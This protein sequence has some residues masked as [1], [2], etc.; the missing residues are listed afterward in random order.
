MLPV[1]PIITAVAPPVLVGLFAALITMWWGAGVALIALAATA[2]A[3]FGGPAFQSIVLVLTAMELLGALRCFRAQALLGNALVV[4]PLNA[5]LAVAYYLS[6]PLRLPLN[7][8]AF[9]A[10]TRVCSIY[11][12]RPSCSGATIEEFIRG[13]QVGMHAILLG[14]DALALETHEVYQLLQRFFGWGMCVLACCRDRSP[15]MCNKY[16]R[17]TVPCAPR[18]DVSARRM[19]RASKYVQRH[20][21]PWL[22]CTFVVRMVRQPSPAPF[23]LNPHPRPY[24]QPPP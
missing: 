2:M 19:R 3:S 11:T 9:W 22:L 15:L 21:P 24:P 17:L 1:A 12:D 23:T 14:A 18:P 16:G 4:L 5:L 13:V 20:V 7:H 8:A 10:V 6:W